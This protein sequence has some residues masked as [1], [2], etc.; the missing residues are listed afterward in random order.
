MYFTKQKRETIF[1]KNYKKFD[2]LKF[3][4]ALNRELMKHGLNNIDYEI[5]HEIVLSILNA[6]APLKKKHLRANHPSFVLKNSEKQ[7]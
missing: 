7:L 5:F 2:N 4:E 1:Y 6:H 3:K